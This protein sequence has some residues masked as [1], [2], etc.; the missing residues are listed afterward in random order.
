MLNLSCP[1]YTVFIGELET[2]NITVIREIES[3]DVNLEIHDFYRSETSPSTFNV[4]F[5]LDCKYL[6][7]YIDQANQFSYF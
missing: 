6:Q 2:C 3:L 7:L 4:S 5:T 1:I